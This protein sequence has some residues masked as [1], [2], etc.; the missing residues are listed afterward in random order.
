MWLNIAA[1]FISFKSQSISDAWILINAFIVWQ[2]CHLADYA[3][4]GQFV[5]HYG[6]VIMGAKASQLTSLTIVYSTVYSGADQRKYQSSVSLAFVRGIHRWLVNSPHKGPEPGKM[7]PFDDV[8]M[9]TS[10]VLYGGSN[11][12]QLNSCFNLTSQRK[13]HLWPMAS[14]A[15]SVFMPRY[16]HEYIRGAPFL[17]WTAPHWLVIS[18]NWLYNHMEAL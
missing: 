1:S 17:L 3:I 2:F 9:V 14:N 4:N 12:Q 8:I 6:D 16:H 7:F 5:S 13:Y 10:H 11:P 15:E 18:N